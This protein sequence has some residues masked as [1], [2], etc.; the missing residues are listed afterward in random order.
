MA[1]YRAVHERTVAF[2]MEATYGVL[3]SYARLIPCD[4][5]MDYKRDS[6]LKP[7]IG[8]AR[9]DT[10][11]YKK[12][13]ALSGNFSLPVMSS[14]VGEILKSF[15]GTSTVTGAGGTFLHTFTPAGTISD[16]FSSMCA[17]I[18]YGQTTV[19]DYSGIR[20]DKLTVSGAAKEE[21]KLSADF[22]GKNETA[23]T[24]CPAAIVYGTLAPI[25]FSQVAFTIDGTVKNPRNFS[26][27]L[28]NGMTDGYRVGTDYNT[29]RPLPGQ[30]MTGLI[31][32]DLDFE[33]SSERNKYIG[34]TYLA[35][36]IL[37]QGESIEAGTGKQELRMTFPRI[38]YQT[39]PFE[40]FD[41]LLGLTVSAF[42]LDGTNTTGTGNAI[43]KAFNTVAA[44]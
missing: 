13:G 3:G 21:L 38:S 9:M 28:N 14:A 23:G 17:K 8:G 25:I 35:L 19:Y 15:F 33:D 41:G 42:V 24:A 36:D 16:G 5:K 30:K 34:G 11:I 18:N 2:G 4:F 7:L 20:I 22:I 6:V 32:F 27:E 1:T 44:Y 40:T 10:A 31:K 37:A 43:F 12:E 29:I 26:V 39:A